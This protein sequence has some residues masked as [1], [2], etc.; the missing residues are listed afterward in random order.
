VTVL[1]VYE[2]AKPEFPLINLST[3]GW[4]DTGNDIMFRMVCDPGRGWSLRGV[5][6]VEGELTT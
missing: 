3:R 5:P 2:V 4:V 6:A 1:A